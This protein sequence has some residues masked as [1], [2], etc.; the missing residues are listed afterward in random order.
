MSNSLNGRQ[1]LKY[2]YDHMVEKADRSGT[3]A[4]RLRELSKNP[5]MSF[6]YLLS[7]KGPLSDDEIYWLSQRLPTKHFQ[8][9]IRLFTSDDPCVIHVTL[10]FLRT[11]NPENSEPAG[12]DDR[13][14]REWWLA[15]RAEGRQ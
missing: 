13:E 1:T 11:A 4:L 8:R 5:E 12:L 3:T 2:V 15:Q 6:K 7:K 10:R 9:F 14:A